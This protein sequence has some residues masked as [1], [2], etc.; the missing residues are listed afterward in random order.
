METRLFYDT[1]G[2]KVSSGEL[3]VNGSR[4]Y[5]DDVNAVFVT[6]KSITGNILSP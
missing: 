5:L 3:I 6:K 2:I 1:D 4:Y